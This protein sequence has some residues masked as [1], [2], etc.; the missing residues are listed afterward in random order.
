MSK[1][2][3]CL[4]RWLN[5]RLPRFLSVGSVLFASMGAGVL[6]NTTTADAAERVVLTYGPFERYLI[7]DE[8][9]TLAETGEASTGIQFLSAV[10][11]QEVSALQDVFT[12]E[13]RLNLRFLDRTLNSLPGEY[14][15]FQAGTVIH[16]PSRRANI[17]AMR[18]ALVLSASDD[19]YVSL[20]EILEN[21]P[22]QDVYLDG[23]QLLQDVRAVSEFVDS[24]GERLSPQLAIAQ[25]I[26][27]GLVCE[28]ESDDAITATSE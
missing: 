6:L 21:Y 9:K 17:Q 28:C 23:P 12:Q 20:L 11:G 1:S 14:A 3:Q 5:C 7:I 13:I 24:V 18:A 2:F 19:N 22:T 25:E 8:L 15:L 26:L 10:S 4:P 16:T 27:E